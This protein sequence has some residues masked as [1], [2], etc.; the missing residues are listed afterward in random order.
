[1]SDVAHEFGCSWSAADGGEARGWVFAPPVTAAQARRLVRTAARTTGCTE[2]PDAAVFGTPSVAVT[3]TDGATQTVSY[4]GLFGDA[5]LACSLQGVGPV[6]PVE[7]A[8]RADR[9]CATVVTSS[10]PG[11]FQP[12]RVLTERSQ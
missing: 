11:T 1:V 7:L 2:L 4:R 9:W 12:D 5:W 10:T 8:E 6:D 3:C